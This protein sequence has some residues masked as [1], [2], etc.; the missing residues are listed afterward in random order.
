[1]DDLERA[2]EEAGSAF[3]YGCFG[4]LGALACAILLVGA[5]LALIAASHP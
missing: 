2:A 1:M 4:C 5:V 3:M